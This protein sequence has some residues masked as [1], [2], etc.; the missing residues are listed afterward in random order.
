MLLLFFFNER[1][2]IIGG[3]IKLLSA[4]HRSLKWQVIALLFTIVMLNLFVFPV[5]CD[6]KGCNSGF[7][8]LR[9]LYSD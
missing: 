6:K 1:R 3:I 4:K 7:C 9:N 8:T 2:L 5:I